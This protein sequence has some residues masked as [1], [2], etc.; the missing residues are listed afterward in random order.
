M[1]EEAPTA[2]AIY[3]FH[4]VRFGDTLFR[5]FP[6]FGFS[7]ADTI[8]LERPRRINYIHQPLY[9]VVLDFVLKEFDLPAQAAH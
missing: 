1:S 8:R 3:A 6:W 9:R 2:Q 4:L 5:D 7:S